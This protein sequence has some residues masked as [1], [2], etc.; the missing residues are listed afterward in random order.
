[1][2]DKEFDS[3][4]MIPRKVTTRQIVYF[5]RNNISKGQLKRDNNGI[6]NLKMFIADVDQNGNWINEREFPINSKDYS[7]GHPS[8]TDD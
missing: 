8:I 5:T 6:Q 3:V 2:A 1:M 4:V 7:V